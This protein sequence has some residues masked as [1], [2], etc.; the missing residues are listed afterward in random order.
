TVVDVA[1]I[2]RQ[3]QSVLDQVA[4]AVQ[5]IFL[6][7]LAAGL[8]VLYGALAASHDE[9]RYE[10]SVLRALGAHRRQ[11][12]GMLLAEF[13][14][15]GALSGLIAAVG[16]QAIGWVLA[17]KVFTLDYQ[18]AFWVFPAAIIGAALLVTGAGW[19]AVSRLL[20][21]PPLEALRAGG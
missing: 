19:L 16:S 3:L 18:F 2:L 8:I 14:A 15:I 10:L 12:R 17:T 21:A 9:R 5:F 20:S 1:A 6:F 13:T 4:R 7:T 11:L